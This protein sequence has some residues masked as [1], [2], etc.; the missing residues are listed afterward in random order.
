MNAYWFK[1]C[2]T[3]LAVGIGTG[4]TGNGLDDQADR[5]RVLVETI[6]F[7]SPNRPDRLWGPPSLLNNGYW[8]RSSLVK[9]R[10]RGADH[11]YPTSAEV[12]KM[13]MYTSTPAYVFMAWCLIS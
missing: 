13:W 12:K 9:Q 6:M 3:T 7:S 2:S 1:R 8:G 11:S 4:A 5:V 10:G